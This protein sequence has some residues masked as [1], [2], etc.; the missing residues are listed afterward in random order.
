[1]FNRR[2]AITGLAATA[3][4]LRP[5][6]KPAAPRKLGKPPRLRPGDTVGLVAP[7]GFVADRFGLDEIS[8]TVRAMG[9]VPKLAANLLERNGYL[10]GSDEHRAA[11]L[12]AM[13]A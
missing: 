12:N 7:A 4:M 6:G 2:S 1:M 9:L 8:E 5:V 11:S 13:F 10:A 3:P